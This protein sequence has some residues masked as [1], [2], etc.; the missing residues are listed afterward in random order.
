VLFVRGKSM[1]LAFA[2]LRYYWWR[3][4]SVTLWHISEG[5]Y[6]IREFIYGLYDMAGDLASRALDEW[7]RESDH[8]IDRKP[9][10]EES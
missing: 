2:R 6:V 9:Y 3:F 4:I 10:G 5:V 8:S 1:T 7:D